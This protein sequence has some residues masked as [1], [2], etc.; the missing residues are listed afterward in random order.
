METIFRP[1]RASD[2]DAAVPLILSSGPAAFSYVFDVPGHGDARAF[3]QR[4]FVHGGG[5]FGWRN[6]VVGELDGRVVA[7]GA[8]WSGR[9]TPAF[10]RAALGQVISHYGAIAGTG[11]AVR[12]LRVEAIVRPPAR[13]VWYVAHLGVPAELRGRGI[14]AA[15]VRHLLELGQSQ[16][17]TST[18]LDVA[19]T[20]A[21]AERL[22]ERFGYQVVA[23][24]A[25]SLANDR[26][27]VPGHR[28]MAAAIARVAAASS[29]ANHRT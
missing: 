16:G 1:A 5:E 15:L 10:T 20:N 4:A 17:Y 9:A 13:D 14:G 24:R 11:V 29:A 6:H 7:A 27:A 8:A 28:R 26:I 23:E 12:G 25:S 21:A 18:E 19:F 3:L 2:A 22:Y